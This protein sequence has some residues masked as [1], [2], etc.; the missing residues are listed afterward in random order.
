MAIRTHST[1]APDRRVKPNFR[2][3]PP[4]RK[5][6]RPTHTD[7]E[8]AGFMSALAPAEVKALHW[9]AENG[10]LIIVA[11]KAWLLTPAPKSLLEIL[12]A[13]GADR[14]DLEPDEDR[15]PAIDDEPHDQ[16]EDYED[17]IDFVA[18]IDGPGD[19]DDAEGFAPAETLNAD[20]RAAA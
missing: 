15:E 5:R 18:P 4:T 16:E 3:K 20:K 7:E 13:V 9:I 1:T 8:L 19:R 10:D 17:S 11:D 12:A 14:A 2:P 6:P